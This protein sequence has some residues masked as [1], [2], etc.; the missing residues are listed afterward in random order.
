MAAVGQKTPLLKGRA[1][2][3][4][5]L[6]RRRAAYHRSMTPQRMGTTRPIMCAAEN[7]QLYDKGGRAPQGAGRVFTIVSYFSG[8]AE[9][10]AWLW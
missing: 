3:V 9:I 7:R 5:A 10:F 1:R 4:A 6:A 8:L 2:G